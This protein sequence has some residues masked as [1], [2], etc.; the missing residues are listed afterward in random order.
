MRV[1]CETGLRV[2]RTVYEEIRAHEGESRVH[3]RVEGFRCSA[4]LAETE[5]SC[6]HRDEWILASTQPTD[7]PGEWHVPAEASQINIQKR[8]AEI[9]I[10]LTSGDSQTDCKEEGSFGRVVFKNGKHKLTLKTANICEP[11]T[12]QN[13]G[14]APGLITSP[15][16]WDHWTPGRI[17]SEV[18]VM[19]NKGRNIE[20]KYRVVV[21]TKDSRVTGRIALHVHRVQHVVEERIYEGT[22]AF[23]NYCIDKGREIRSRNG[24]LFCWR[25][26]AWE[27]V[28]WSF[29]FHYSR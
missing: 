27:T 10:N 6:Q 21:Q 19:L 15:H 26:G 5:V 3:Y 25:V 13:Y 20:A 7:H 29:A 17:G 24:R 16:V 11:G 4:V 18:D 9:N 2:A 22:D 8:P 12:W 28:G 1:D 14:S 23:V